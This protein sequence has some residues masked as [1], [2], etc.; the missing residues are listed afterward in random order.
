M[1]VWF[2]FSSSVYLEH[3]VNTETLLLLLLLVALVCIGNKS[4][5][6]HIKEG[7]G[8]HKGSR[9]EI[10]LFRF[11]WPHKT[12]GVLKSRKSNHQ[13]VHF[14]NR[15][16]NSWWCLG[17]ITYSYLLKIAEDNNII[18]F[19]NQS[20]F[21]FFFH[22]CSSKYIG[23]YPCSIITPH[24]HRKREQEHNA[25]GYFTLSWTNTGWWWIHTH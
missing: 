2:S 10:F 16:H 1:N 19:R 13:E 21:Y 9:N 17:I 11:E 20:Y 25:V 24:T 3:I 8:C 4:R 22:F 18:I 15:P 23:H 6:G 14:Q 12:I 7:R 5:A